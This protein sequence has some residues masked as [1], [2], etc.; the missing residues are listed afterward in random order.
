MQ[1]ST[2]TYT[3][4]YSV[5]YKPGVV[6]I[7]KPCSPLMICSEGSVMTADTKTPVVQCGGKV[8]S[9][10]NFPFCKK[11]L[12]SVDIIASS[13]QQ[14]DR[15]YMPKQYQLVYKALS[16]HPRVESIRQA[17]RFFCAKANAFKRESAYTRPEAMLRDDS[18]NRLSSTVHR[19]TYYRA[20]IC[21]EKP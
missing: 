12:E 8:N 3:P 2:H 7:F 15:G 18:A 20:Q 10:Q 21:S 11:S 4:G 6:D 13:H 19:S 17:N 9:L 1:E 16:P 14:E 5:L